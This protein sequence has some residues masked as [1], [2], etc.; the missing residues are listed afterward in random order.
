SAWRCSCAQFLV[1]VLRRLGQTDA[2]GRARSALA[3]D[4][5]R[6]MVVLDDV[7]GDGQAEAG[8]LTAF[9]GGEEWVHHRRQM[10]ARNADAVVFDLENDAALVLRSAGSDMAVAARSAGVA[11]V[12]E[13]VDEHLLELAGISRHR[14]HGQRRLDDELDLGVAKPVLEE[15]ARVAEGL[16]RR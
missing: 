16:R 10:L 14:R 6:A 3:L 13:E 2:N 9:F 5:E 15:G 4:F 1:G 11:S 8:A 7:G 12:D